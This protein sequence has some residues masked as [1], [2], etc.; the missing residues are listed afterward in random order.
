MRVHRDRV[1]VATADPLTYS[2]HRSPLNVT[3][4]CCHWFGVSGAAPCSTFS[5]PL[6]AMTNL[7]PPAVR[8]RLQDTCSCWR[9][10]RTRRSAG[11]TSPVPSQRTHSWIV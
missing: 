10:G 9:R 5:T 4:T 3:A 6:T 8:R 1:L 7:T 11:S 2:R